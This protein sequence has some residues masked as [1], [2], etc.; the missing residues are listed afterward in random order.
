MSKSASHQNG[1][2]EVEAIIDSKL[3]KDGSK[4]YFV[5]WKGYPEE[6]S[7]WEPIDHLEHCKK[8]IAEYEKNHR[9][10]KTARIIEKRQGSLEKDDKIKSLV[11][12]IYDPERNEA[13]VEVEWED[14]NLY[15]GFYPVV[16]MHKYCPKEMCEL[17]LK[18][19]S[20]TYQINS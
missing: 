2:F 18:N 16:E 10:K 1:E 5:K 19:L 17:Y 8:A 15:N 9:A 6:E 14:P 13:M 11:Q 3:K 7:T 20:F 4:L 12:I